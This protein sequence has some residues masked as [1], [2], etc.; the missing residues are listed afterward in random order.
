MVVGLQNKAA[1]NL[2]TDDVSTND[3]TSITV[4]AAIFILVARGFSAATTTHNHLYRHNERCWPY[5]VDDY[6]TLLGN[7]VEYFDQVYH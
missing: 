3:E 7:G 2:L 4:A 1:I 5:S 6:S